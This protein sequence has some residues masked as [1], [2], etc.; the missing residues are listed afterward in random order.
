MM[1]VASKPVTVRG[2]VG[3]KFPMF[4]KG[5]SRNAIITKGMILR[6]VR[7]FSVIPENDIP[8]IFSQQKAPIITISISSTFETPN[9]A[10]Y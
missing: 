6:V 10:I 3:E 2:V 7:I 5:M 9:Q 8:V 1:I 4:I